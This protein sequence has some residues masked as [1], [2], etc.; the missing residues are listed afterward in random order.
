MKGKRNGY[1]LVN[2]VVEGSQ[3]GRIPIAYRLHRIKDKWWA[4]DVVIQ[5]VSMMRNYRSQFQSI[6]ARKSFADLLQRL[7]QKNLQN[8]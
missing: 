8:E 2:V 5:G 6:L 3:T 7:K 1:A 4:Y